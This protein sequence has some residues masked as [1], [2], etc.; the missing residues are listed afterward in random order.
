MKFVEIL[1]KILYVADFNDENNKKLIF[2]DNIFFFY[3]QINQNKK[4]KTNNSSK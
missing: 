4:T 3:M 1:I 2:N